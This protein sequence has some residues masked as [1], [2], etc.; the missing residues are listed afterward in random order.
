MVGG[1]EGVLYAGVGVNSRDWLRT[2]TPA[3]AAVRRRYR[4]VYAGVGVYPPRA[5]R[6]YVPRRIN[7]VTPRAYARGWKKLS[8]Q[9][10]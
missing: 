9:G 8:P 7:V 3:H 4:D 1:G 5:R 10:G 2:P 6:G